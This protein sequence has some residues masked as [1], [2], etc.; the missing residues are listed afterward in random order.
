MFSIINEL[1]KHISCDCKFKFD[2]RKCNLNYDICQC[3]CK[4]PITH[5]VCEED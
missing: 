5:C 1:K 2:G 3:E 4:K